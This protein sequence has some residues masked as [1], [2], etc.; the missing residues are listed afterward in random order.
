[1][2]TPSTVSILGMDMCAIQKFLFHF[3]SWLGVQAMLDKMLQTST[4]GM[5]YIAEYKSGHLEHK[6]DHLACFAGQSHSS[7]VMLLQ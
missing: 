3:I 1:M 5:K 2:Y 6:M 4:S 7:L